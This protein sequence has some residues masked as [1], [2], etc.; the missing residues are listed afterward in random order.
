M[1]VIKVLYPLE[2]QKT[3]KCMLVWWSHKKIQINNF[4]IPA[5]ILIYVFVEN[6]AIS[7]KL[8][9]RGI[10]PHPTPSH[11]L[12]SRIYNIDSLDQL[13]KN[14]SDV[15]VILDYSNEGRG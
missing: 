7:E 8:C 12:I 6:L 9:V 2:G 10:P 11:P 13:S 15:K 5:F 3:P 14:P 4:D 1:E